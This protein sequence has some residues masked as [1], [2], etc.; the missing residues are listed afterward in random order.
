[1]LIPYDSLRPKY[2][3]ERHCIISFLFGFLLGES[4]AHPL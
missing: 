1:M 4:H 3:L 2:T